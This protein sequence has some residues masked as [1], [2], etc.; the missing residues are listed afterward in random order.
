VILFGEFSEMNQ[1]PAPS[2]IIWES[3]GVDEGR[4]LRRRL[5][6]YMI[7]GF[8]LFATISCKLKAE[9]MIR[10]FSSN[11]NDALSCDT[12]K[13]NFTEMQIEREAANEFQAHDNGS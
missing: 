6:L 10:L 9:E 4:K 5:T 13:L 8:L 12:L 7:I 1:A 11:Y 2:D 3:F